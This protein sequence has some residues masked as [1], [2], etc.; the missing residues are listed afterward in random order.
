[1]RALCAD[2][3]ND[4]LVWNA[5]TALAEKLRAEKTLT[6]KQIHAF[7]KGRLKRFSKRVGPG[8]GSAD[9]NQKPLEDS[10]WSILPSSGPPRA[11]IPCVPATA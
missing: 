7:L 11:G 5:V 10:S 9:L 1:V 2:I 4:K 6:G 3:L 8:R